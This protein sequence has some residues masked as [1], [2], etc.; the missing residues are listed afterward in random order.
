MMSEVELKIEGILRQVKRPLTPKEIAEMIG[1]NTNTVRGR[2]FYLQRRGRIR[3][4]AK[5]LYEHA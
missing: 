2:L 3:K 4:V 1:A 5:G